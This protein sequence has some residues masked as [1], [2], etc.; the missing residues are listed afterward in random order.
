[1]KDVTD[2]EVD[3]EE[4]TILH[5]QMKIPSYAQLCFGLFRAFRADIVE[6]SWLLTDA[7]IENLH[8]VGRPY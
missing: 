2:S 4:C 6:I 8:I 5:F 1:M 7:Q 3:A